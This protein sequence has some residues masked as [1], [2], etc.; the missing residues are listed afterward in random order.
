MFS[1]MPV[2]CKF[3]CIHYKPGTV[4]PVLNGHPR[5]MTKQTLNRGDR[6]IGVK[7]AV[8]KGDVIFRTLTTDCSIQGDHLR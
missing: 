7:I 3:K 5:E 6:S 1:S 2:K 8:S 4:E